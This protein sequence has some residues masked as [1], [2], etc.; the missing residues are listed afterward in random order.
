[1]S[2][3]KSLVFYCLLYLRGLFLIA[4]KLIGFVALLTGVVTFLI[5]TSPWIAACFVGVSF[6]IFMLRQF[7][8]SILLKLTPPGKE[9]ILVQ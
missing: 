9:Y 1:M 2:L 6:G 4:G 5:G 7:Y 3:V 8:D